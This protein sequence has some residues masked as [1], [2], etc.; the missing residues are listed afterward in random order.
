[1]SKADDYWK[2]ESRHWKPTPRSLQEA[3][4]QDEDW[5]DSIDN[6][7]AAIGGIVFLAFVAFVIWGIV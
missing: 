6:I 7:G 1:M 2:A 5:R 4:L 3:G